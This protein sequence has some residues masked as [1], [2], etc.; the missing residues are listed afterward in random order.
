MLSE[1]IVNKLLNHVLK[2]TSYAPP[3]NI[4]IALLTSSGECTGT[5]YSRVLCNSWA[6]TNSRE[7]GNNIKIE[8]P[9]AGNDWGTITAVA[10]YDGTNLIAQKSITPK[11]V[12][13]GENLWIG[14]NALTVKFKPNGVTNHWAD[15]LLAHLFKISALAQPTNLYVGLSTQAVGDNA[16]G[17][18][19]PGG[20]Y[21]RKSSSWSVVG[22]VASNS[23]VIEFA[24]ASSSWGTITHSFV[25]DHLTN[26]AEANIIFHGAANS[27][28][29]GTNDTVKANIGAIQVKVDEE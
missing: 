9:E 16:S 1:Y 28:N 20:N 3:T 10:V 22:K 4:H 6:K 11:P 25:S 13:A 12:G 8:F 26:T 21:A 18:S 7:V 24:Q 17:I 27:I 2:N 5:T 14:V 23:Q 29:I 19:E 15:K